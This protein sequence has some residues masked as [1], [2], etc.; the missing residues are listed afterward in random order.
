MTQEVNQVGAEGVGRDERN[1]KKNISRVTQKQ[2]GRDEGN[3][4]HSEAEQDSR[5]KDEVSREL[6][7]WAYQ[8]GMG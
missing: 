4:M 5:D 7:V 2:D 1:M 8:R 6:E 3:A